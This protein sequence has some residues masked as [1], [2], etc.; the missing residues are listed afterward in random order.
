VSA[1]GLQLVTAIVESPDPR[2]A[3]LHILE[4]QKI[5]PQHFLNA[6]ARGAY[7]FINYWFHRPTEFGHVPSRQR[8]EEQFPQM[9][10]P[11]AQEPL[12]DFGKTVRQE[13]LSRQLQAIREEFKVQLQEA[14]P[15]EAL[16]F[17]RDRIGHL[18]EQHVVDNDVDFST[19]GPQIVA[20]YLK[21]ITTSGGLLGIPWPWDQL[22]EATQ[23]MQ[24]EDLI[25]FF[26]LP[27]SMKTWL[28]L[29]LTIHLIEH[30]YKV[31]VFSR[32]MSATT[33]SLRC[34]SVM[35]KLNYSRLRAGN[36]SLEEYTDL[37]CAMDRLE[38]KIGSGKL[39]FTRASKADGSPGGV[40][41]IQRKVQRYRPDLVVLDSA[42]MMTNDRAGG[43]S[44]KWGDLAAISQD[45]KQ[46]ATTAG[47]PTIMIWQENESKAMKFK[48]SGAR[49]TASLAMASQLVYYCD[50]AIRCVL[51]EEKQELSLHLA[52]TR[53]F[54]HPGFTIHAKPGHNFSF[55]SYDLHDVAEKSTGDP[56][57]AAHVP[58][59][60]LAALSAATHLLSTAETEH[61]LNPNTEGG[62]AGT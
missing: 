6:E 49:G 61:C 27:K 40:S 26:G 50:M 47:V 14:E 7:E 30:N 33:M 58:K 1:W 23:G 51:Q 53:E 44:L 32:E 15:E 52:A 46:M 19:S 31:L 41:D 29:Y 56:G 55:I 48:G 13:L 39:M 42:Y 28:V 62:D 25:V 18:D 20:D 12:K 22:N 37:A 3:F 4:D 36:L 34:A 60:Q 8:L 38:K 21:Q 35:A 24:K 11:P 16:N 54:K 59:D 43:H 2:A 10:F 17:L 9:T 45:V 57:T 5:T